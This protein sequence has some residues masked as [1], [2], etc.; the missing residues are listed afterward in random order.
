MYNKLLIQ[1]SVDVTWFCRVFLQLDLLCDES[2][3][4]KDST[5]KFIW[6]SLWLK[7]VRSHTYARVF[8]LYLFGGTATAVHCQ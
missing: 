7:K 1:F 5:L 2:V 4:H 6:L 3:L 8:T